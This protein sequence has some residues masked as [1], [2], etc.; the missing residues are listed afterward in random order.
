MSCPVYIENFLK[1]FDNP[2]EAF[3][4]KKYIIL[5]AP[6]KILVIENK[7]TF[8]NSYMI[9]SY[10][11]DFYFGVYNSSKTY[12]KKVIEQLGLTFVEG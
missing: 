2:E 7:N 11:D 10:Y 9:K 4:A 5:N 3:E 12:T 6:V 8:R 1:K